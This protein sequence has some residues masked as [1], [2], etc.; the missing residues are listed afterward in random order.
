M[1]IAICLRLQKLATT[2]DSPS[3]PDTHLF[4][5]LVSRRSEAALGIVLS[6]YIEGSLRKLAMHPVADIVIAKALERASRN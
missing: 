4:E 2:Y 3:R 1:Q 5:T 6:T